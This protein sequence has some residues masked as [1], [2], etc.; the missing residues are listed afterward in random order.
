MLKIVCF[1]SVIVLVMNHSVF[2]MA[3]MLHPYANADK[4]SI[5]TTLPKEVVNKAFNANLN[6][7]GL[8]VGEAAIRKAGKSAGE[9]SVEKMLNYIHSKTF[10][11]EVFEAMVAKETGAHY[12]KQNTKST[13]L[14]RT[15]NKKPI[16][17]QL[18]MYK[19]AFNG[20]KSGLID[21]MTFAGG[22]INGLELVKN[23]Q[24][25]ICIPKDKYEELVKKGLLSKDG[26]ANKKLVKSAVREAKNIKVAAGENAKRL[27]TLSERDLYIVG[28]NA[29]FVPSQSTYAE[30][31]AKCKA[32]IKDICKKVSGEDIIVLSGKTVAKNASAATKVMS[33]AG[34]CVGK[35]IGVAGFVVA[36]VIYVI[37]ENDAQNM[38]LDGKIDQYELDKMQTK[39]AIQLGMSTATCAAFSAI[40][41]TGCAT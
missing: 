36:P 15:I 33:T 21:A 30:I 40:A 18:K 10:H 39:N 5:K 28:R 27:A 23:K 29:K 25:E 20:A 13:D 2:G 31:I 3:Q 22:N 38:Y 17:M 12:T 41:I 9:V 24:F 32:G 26:F 14:I 35:A 37:D 34:K 8:V 6:E 16:F 1:L 19:N 7:S 4:T 11:G